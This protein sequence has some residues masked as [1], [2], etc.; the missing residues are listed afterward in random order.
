MIKYIIKLLVVAGS[1]L[2]AQHFVDG[3]TVD[4]FWPTA[5]LAAFIF[6]VLSVTVR[7]L[8]KLFALPITFL[9]LGL[10]GLLINIL[11]FWLITFVP[12]MTIDGFMPAVWG[13]IIVTVVG[14]IADAILK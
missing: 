14:W 13:L 5:I 11:V 7:P 12:G 10:F 2:L 9:T 4:S 8:L 3:I 6:G 1:L